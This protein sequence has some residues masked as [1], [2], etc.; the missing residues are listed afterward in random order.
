MNPELKDVLLHDL[1]KR[2]SRSFYLTLTVLPRTIRTQIGLAYLFARAADTIADT[3]IID[4]ARRQRCLAL[5]REQFQSSGSSHEALEDIRAAFDID[6]PLEADLILLTRLNDCFTLF[7]ALTP[8]DQDRIRNLMLTLINGMDMDLTVFPPSASSNI[9]ALSTLHELDIYTYYVAG[10]V[11]EFWTHLSIAHVP[12]LAH[13]ELSTM[14]ER[15][16]RF[17]KGLQMTNILKDLPKDLRK[18]RCYLPLSLLQQ[19]KL[20]PE[21]LLTPEG[22]RAA[23]PILTQLIDLTIEHLD[24]GWQYTLSIPRRA[25]RLRLACLWPILF[26]VKTLRHVSAS[27]ERHDPNIDAKMPRKE[28][29]A[30]MFFSSM[31]I[32]SNTLLTAYYH[33]R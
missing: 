27:I 4:M 25:I 16:I 23:R 12:S 11:G 5:F 31:V 10:C 6:Q 26:A 33:Q 7:H 8:S 9:I 17:G 14:C 1:L 13:W 30:T 24:M 2:V 32:A 18:G 20:T 29:Y 15:G 28:V 19:Y 22:L 3:H 21:D